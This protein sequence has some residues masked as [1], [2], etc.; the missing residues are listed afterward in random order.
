M[1][2]FISLC[3]DQDCEK[4]SQHATDC[5]YNESSEGQFEAAQLKEFPHIVSCALW[6]NEIGSLF[7]D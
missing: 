3:T 5:I 4:Y 7:Y 2:K 6:E 1:L